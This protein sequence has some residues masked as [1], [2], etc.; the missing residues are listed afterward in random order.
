MIDKWKETWYGLI[1]DLI[2]HGGGGGGS[3]FL[4]MGRYNDRDT[5]SS[6]VS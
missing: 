4:Q 1:L 6:I 2:V 3:G 5:L